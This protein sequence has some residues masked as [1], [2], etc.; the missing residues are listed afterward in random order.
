MKA[1]LIIDP[2][3]GTIIDPSEDCIIH[4]IEVPEGANSLDIL[5][6]H[7]PGLQKGYVS[8]PLHRPKIKVKKTGWV[9]VWPAGMGLVTHCGPIYDTKEVAIEKSKGDAIDTVPITYEVEE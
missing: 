3:G 6:M 4:Q 8:I 5:F 1:Q 7:R 2:S 9:N